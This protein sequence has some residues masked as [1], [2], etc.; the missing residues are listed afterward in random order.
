ME[1]ST[2]IKTSYGEVPLS[3]LISS[4]EQRK[5][6]DKKKL[7]WL[8]TE[9]GKQYNRQNAKNYY[10]QHKE[11]ILKKRADKYEQNREELLAKNKKYYADN[12][13]KRK[14]KQAEYRKRKVEERV[15]TN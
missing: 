5:D 14:L 13:E 4:Y 9:E 11:E 10:E 1:L 6:W 12:K 2:L 8:Q 15:E 7:E 3:T